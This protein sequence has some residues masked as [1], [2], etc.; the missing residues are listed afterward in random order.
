MLCILSSTVLAQRHVLQISNRLARLKWQKQKQASPNPFY[1]SVNTRKNCRRRFDRSAPIKRNCHCG[2]VNQNPHQGERTNFPQILTPKVVSI[3]RGPT[4]IQPQIFF[5]QLLYIIEK[6][7]FH[8]LFSLKSSDVDL[9]LN[10]LSSSESETV[11]N[12]SSVL[13][14]LRSLALVGN[15]YSF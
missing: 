3:F 4:M 2:I 15:L 5:I 9:A 6:T 11:T 7:L 12:G 1:C 14:L 13:P 8:I 10:F